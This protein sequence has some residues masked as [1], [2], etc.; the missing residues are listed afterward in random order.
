MSSLLKWQ[1]SDVQKEAFSPSVVNP[2][3]AHKIASACL[4]VPHVLS[5]DMLRLQQVSFL[6][7]WGQSPGSGVR[8]CLLEAGHEIQLLQPAAPWLKDPRHKS[9]CSWLSSWLF[10]RPSFHQ[11][12]RSRP[13]GGK[14]C[15]GGLTLVSAAPYSPCYFHQRSS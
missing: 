9:P 11:A 6:S 15:D 8:V 2:A 10:R 12:R 7:L 5:K 13:W 4:S 1:D 3:E 14:G